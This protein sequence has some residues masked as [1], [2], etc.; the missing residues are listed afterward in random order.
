MHIL[1]TLFIFYPSFSTLVMLITL[2]KYI[3]MRKRHGLELSSP[4]VTYLGLELSSPGMTYP[5]LELS[6]HGM[7]DY[8]LQLS[9]PGMKDYGL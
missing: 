4:G 6:S 9:S 5:G 2:L 8:G 7:T 1:E 3:K